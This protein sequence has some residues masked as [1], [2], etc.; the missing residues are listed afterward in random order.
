MCIRDSSLPDHGLGFRI[1]DSNGKPVTHVPSEMALIMRDSTGFEFNREFNQKNY[2]LT[3]VGFGSDKVNGNLFTGRT[4]SGENIYGVA[5]FKNVQ[6]GQHISLGTGVAVSKLEG[7]RS[8][9]TIDQENLYV[10]SNLELTSPS[11][12]LGN[13]ETKGIA[14]GSIETLISNNKETYKGSSYV[15]EAKKEIDA[16]ADMHLGVQNNYVSNDQKTKVESV[17]YANFY[18]DWNHVASGDKTVPVYDGLVV[19]SGVS[20]DIG[21]DKKIMIDTAVVM[22]NYGTNLVMKASYSDNKENIRYIAGLSA[23][24]TRDMPTFLPGGERRLFLGAEKANKN[25]IFSIEYEKNFDN[26]AQSVMLKAKMAL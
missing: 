14:G 26:N 8:V 5:L 18:P 13:F 17:V 20:H 7:Q 1:Y 16:T 23:P 15:N 3:S 2:S 12:K 11:W 24:L 21:D 19:R 25:M 10:R 9:M 4:S 6:Y 22:K